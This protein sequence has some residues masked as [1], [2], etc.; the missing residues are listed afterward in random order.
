MKTLE[1]LI[2]EHPFFHDLDERHLGLLVGCASNRVYQPEEF[3]C[4]AGDPADD[5]FIIREGHVAI[6]I[7]RPAQEI[8][9]IQTVGSGEVMGW[10]WLIPPHRW[11]FDGRALDRT[12][13]VA[14]DGKCLRG[15]CDDDH[16]FGYELLTRFSTILVDRL[17]ATRMQ[18]MDV[19]K[20]H[21]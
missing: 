13:V 8:I 11:R 9:R 6:E 16:A 10:S 14:L 7:A 3:L 5:F 4:R 12:R 15:K 2:A 17:E 19:Y 20:S 18:L 21:A 1:P